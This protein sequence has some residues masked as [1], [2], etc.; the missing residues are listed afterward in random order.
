MMK[1]TGEIRNLESLNRVVL[2]IEMR[3]AKDLKPYDFAEIYIR[4]NGDIIVEKYDAKKYSKSNN[5]V[6][7][8]RKLDAIGRIV[9]PKPIIEEL[10]LKKSDLI[11]FISG[12]QGE[13]ILR[14]YHQKCIFC[15]QNKHTFPFKEK[16]ICEECLKEITKFSETTK[17]V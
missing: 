10:Q 14:K 16:L 5:P 15:G 12:T 4:E 7:L 8:I 3:Q 6:G 11:E 17:A 9:I 13:I 1:L 2:P